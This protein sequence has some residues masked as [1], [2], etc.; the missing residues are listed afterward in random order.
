MA[1]VQLIQLKPNV[2]VDN[3]K[4]LKIIS[5]FRSAEGGTAVV[6]A[7]QHEDSKMAGIAACEYIPKISSLPA[8]ANSSC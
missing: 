2:G 5:G 1:A 4:W 6:W 7:L 3:E 8:N